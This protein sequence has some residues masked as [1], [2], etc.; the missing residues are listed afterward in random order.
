MKIWY[1]SMTVDGL[2]S[3]YTSEVRRLVDLATGS[4][5]ETHIAGIPH[6]SEHSDHQFRYYE[7]VD[8]RH[9]V[10]HAVR[11]EQEGYSAFLIGNIADPGLETARELTRFPVL[12]LGELSFFL[13]RQ[14]GRRIGLV[15]VTELQGHHVMEKA[16][17]LGVARHVAGVETLDL[18]KYRELYGAYSDAPINPVLAAFEDRVEKL[19]DQ[20][21]DVI[22]PVGG[23]MMAALSRAG[24]SAVG[25]VPIINGVYTLAALGAALGR[26][27]Q[28]QGHFTSKHLAYASP[29]AEALAEIVQRSMAEPSELE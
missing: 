4:E 6:A 9:V 11:A 26:L 8:T 22:I 5:C 19:L 29:P 17:E 2:N 13:A 24:I 10:S 27:Y 1:Q 18:A 15:T 7:M 20:G 3:D 23:L 14:A 16:E 21:A 25:N 28:V 12:G